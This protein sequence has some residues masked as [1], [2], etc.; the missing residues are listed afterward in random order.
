MGQTIRFPNSPICPPHDWISIYDDPPE[1]EVID[2]MDEEEIITGRIC[3]KCSLVQSRGSLALMW[4]AK[5]GTPS[6]S[7]GGRGQ[8]FF[9]GIVEPLFNSGEPRD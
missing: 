3:V 7:S 1:S 9:L 5:H 4:A 6:G 2:G 8:G